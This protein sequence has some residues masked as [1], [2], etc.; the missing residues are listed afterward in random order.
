MNGLLWELAERW[1]LQPTSI[2]LLPGIRLPPCSIQTPGSRAWQLA[3]QSSGRS[4]GE[5]LFRSAA[6]FTNG[7]HQRPRTKANANVSHG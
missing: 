6:P 1:S 7:V 2:L 4:S 5:I 3:G